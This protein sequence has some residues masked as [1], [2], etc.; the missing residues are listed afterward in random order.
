MGTDGRTDGR[1]DNGIG[2]GADCGNDG[3]SDGCTA[4]GTDR[5]NVAARRR[6]YRHTS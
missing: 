1:T 6:R 3:G 5:G 2:G 4:I